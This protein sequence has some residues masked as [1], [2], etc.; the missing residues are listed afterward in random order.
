MKR[1]AV[2]PLLIEICKNG[3]CNLI[4]ECEKVLEDLLGP[5]YNSEKLN[6]SGRSAADWL[7]YVYPIRGTNLELRRDWDIWIW[8]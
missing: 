1:L 4:C 6:F 2:K 8:F 5:N 3:R 7:E